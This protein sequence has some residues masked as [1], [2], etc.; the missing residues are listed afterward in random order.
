M[1]VPP[2]SGLPDP[3]NVT[4]PGLAW[5]LT[6]VPLQEYFLVGKWP[7]QAWL[8]DDRPP[9]YMAWQAEDLSG[10]DEIPKEKN[11]RKRVQL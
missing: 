3:P 6:I 8:Y 1:T 10:P 4:R 9:K 7:D 2:G 11:W 5:L